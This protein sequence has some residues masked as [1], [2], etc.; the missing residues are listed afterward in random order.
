[1]SRKTGLASIGLMS[2]PVFLTFAVPIMLWLAN[3]LVAIPQYCGLISSIPIILSVF[4]WQGR[5]RAFSWLPS[6]SFWKASCFFMG[7]IITALL[8][9]NIINHPV[10]KI[11]GHARS[12]V[13]VVGVIVLLPIAEELVFRGVI[14]SIFKRVSKNIRWSVVALAGTSLLFGIQHLGYWAQSQWPLPPDA[15]IHSLSMVAAGACFG[16]FRQASKSLVVP[17][18]VHMFANGAILLTQQGL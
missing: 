5:T 6:S 13:E 8:V 3:K 11:T 2:I 4:L 17:M 18:A 12:P 9:I 15:F 7:V 10:S 1:M 14:W 16:I